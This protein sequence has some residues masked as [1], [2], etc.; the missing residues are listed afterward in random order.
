MTVIL[1]TTL[2]EATAS[3]RALPLTVLAAPH[4]PDRLLGSISVGFPLE[5]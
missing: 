4:A 3:G 1:G 2:A 5:R